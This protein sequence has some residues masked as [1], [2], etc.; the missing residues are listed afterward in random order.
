MGKRCGLSENTTLSPYAAEVIG[1]ELGFKQATMSGGVNYDLRAVNVPRL[2]GSKL[3]WATRL[4]ENPLTRPLLLGQLLRNGGVEKLRSLVVEDEPSFQPYL[5]WDTP[6]PRLEIASV[7]T[8]VGTVKSHYDNPCG[9]VGVLDYGQAYETGATT[10]EQVAQRALAAISASETCTP[11]LRMFIAYQND[12]V[13]A[14]AQASTQRWHAGNPLGPFDG[15][16]VAIKDEFDLLPYRS[17]I[18]SS[19]LGQ[20]LP[21]EEATVVTR[22]RESGAL[23]LGKTNMHEFGIGVTGLNPH[24]GAARNPYQPAH[25]AGGSSGGSAAAV[26][27]GLCPVAIGTDG[28]GSIRIPAAFCGV[29]GLKPTYGRISGFGSPT[30]ACSVCQPG[31]IGATV[32]D[33]AMAYGVIAGPDSRDRKSL[34]QP[35]V[36]LRGLA[37][38]DLTGLTLGVY[39][40][41]FKHADSAVVDACQSLLDA[42]VGQGAQLMD[43]EIP[44]L[45]IGRIA[46]AI[47]I[48]AELGSALEPYYDTHRRDI[49]W[50][51]RIHLVLARAMTARDYLQ[52]QR[53]RTRMTAHF[54][55]ALQKADMI[56][57]P[58]TACSAPLIH[59]DA[60]PE[61]EAD[62]GLATEIMRFVV[63]AN[64]A[65]LP[66]ISF[67]AGYDAQGLPI[68]FHAIGRPWEE[69][70]LLR[71]ASVAERLVERRPAQVHYDLLQNNPQPV[72]SNLSAS[73]S[74]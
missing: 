25:C 14:Q 35:P 62:L 27:S 6:V 67:P 37:S 66:A 4:L 70:E 52:A 1:N 61:G 36:S 54:Y 64:F 31:P 44:E 57:T 20:T 40:A 23:L 68:G 15:V 22:L 28:G 7:P 12:A 19:F 65:G 32:R 13:M 18:G 21:Y 53:I 43:I 51:T 69:H 24:Y 16:P 39:P 55:R 30:Q 45:D 8:L 2:T 59:A 49:S 74:S 63:P 3:R 29:V 33:V 42:F 34:I 17:T 46:H 38:L 11:P 26:A 56:V 9:F 71:L 41:W 10:P 5:F 73:R 58:T 50:D 72:D 48:L 47:T 60:L